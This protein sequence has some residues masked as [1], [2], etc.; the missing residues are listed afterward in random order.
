MHE[1]VERGRDAIALF[2]E[3]GDRWGEVMATG[4]RRARARRARP[5]Q[6][7][8]RHARALP[9]DLARHARRRHAPLPRDHGVARRPPAGPARCRAGD[10]RS[11]RHRPR[12]RQ[13]ASSASP[14]ATRRPASRC[15]SSARSTT[16]SRVLARGYAG[17]TE[18]G[19]AM[20][21]GCRLALAYAA[22][23]RP[24]DA[25]RV[26][27]RAAAP[28]RAARSPTA[29]SRCGPRASCAP[30]RARPTRATAIDAAYD[31]RDR[32][33]RAARA[34]DRRARPGEGARARSAP[35]TRATR[36]T[37]AALQL[38]ALGLTADGWCADLR[39]RARRASRFPRRTPARRGA[40][41]ARR[42]TRG[43]RRTSAR[44]AAPRRSSRRRARPPRSG[45]SARGGGRRRAR[46]SRVGREVFAGPVGAP[47]RD[48]VRRPGSRTRASAPSTVSR[49]GDRRARRERAVDADGDAAVDAERRGEAVFGGARVQLAVVVGPLGDVDA[50]VARRPSATSP[51]HQRNVSTACEPHAPIQPPPRSRSNS[52]P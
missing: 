52:Q 33:R 32:D 47:D 27:A 9:R 13:T 36:P 25:D 17:A 21:I 12:G 43:R 46:W 49:G 16:R 38:D 5:R 39:P 26:I 28:R 42:R 1:S 22:A 23:H 11:P 4:P 20:A 45:A 37:E 41:R 24:D 31:D 51:K 44:P 8:R 19:P 10:P 6:R 2:Q 29:S 30:S 35:T 18:D 7:V 48:R 40:G 15:S 14:T 3:I 34:R 50:R